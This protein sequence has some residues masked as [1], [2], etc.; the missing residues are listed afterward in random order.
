VPNGS[1]ASHKILETR[2]CGDRVTLTLVLDRH[3]AANVDT[4]RLFWWL[5]SPELPDGRRVT[6]LEAIEMMTAEILR[7]FRLGGGV[8]DEDLRIEA[9]QSIL[10]ASFLWIATPVVSPVPDYGGALR[11][12][13]KELVEAIAEHPDAAARSLYE[14]FLSSLKKSGN[15][16]PGA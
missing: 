12:F 2:K 7:P 4:S 14:L 13:W 11:T 9:A 16:G 5:V 3:G 10:D 15:Q 6:A 1:G 8:T